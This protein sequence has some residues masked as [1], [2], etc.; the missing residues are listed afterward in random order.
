MNEIR[1]QVQND[2]L[3]AINKG[4]NV[5]VAVSMGVGKTLIGLRHM[6]YMYND[7]L[8]VL[9]V[10]PK[11]AILKSWKDEAVKFKMEYLLN[12]IT[13]STYVSLNKQSLKALPSTAGIGFSMPFAEGGGLYDNI[14][15]K[16]KRIAQ[17]SGEKMRKPGSKG[18]PTA[19][20][21]KQSAK[22][23]KR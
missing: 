19:E 13:F 7:S 20:A 12:H 21:F 18:A 2:A 9:V 5:G 1:Q 8:N 17:G 23:A 4:D 22:T 16:R 10:A 14:N 3:H 11:K 15:A 6:E